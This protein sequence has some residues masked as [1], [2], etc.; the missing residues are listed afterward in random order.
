MLFTVPTYRRLGGQFFLTSE[1]VLFME[2]QQ[3]Q[4]QMQINT[5]SQI[6]R[7]LISISNEFSGASQILDRD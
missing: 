4:Q 7:I 5:N 1:E 2:G 3:Q 6:H